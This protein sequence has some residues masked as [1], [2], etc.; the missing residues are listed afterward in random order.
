MTATASL[1]CLR[2][3]VVAG[4][5]LVSTD[6]LAQQN[7]IVR[8]RVL[9]PENNAL[10]AQ[11]VLLHRVDSFGGS[12]VA[13]DT[14]D[15]TG[16]FELRVAAS[17]D[18]GAVFFVA[19]RFE[20]ELYIGP[21]FR[22][23]QSTEVE[24]ILQVGV[25]GTSAEQLLRGELPPAQTSGGRPATSRSWLLMLIPLLGVVTVALYALFARNR[26]P[27]DRALLIR[28]A[29]LDERMG[30]ATDGQRATMSE[31]RVRLIAQLRGAS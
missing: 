7:L 26:I 12:T 1:R 18:T 17:P 21:P 22:P 24:Q 6:A 28:V 15:A 10:A 23:E 19:S 11:R 8:G 16:R 25:P 31:E 3:L 4:G 14:S 9:G 30:M 27:A 2:L 13:E 20:E 29:E 5:L